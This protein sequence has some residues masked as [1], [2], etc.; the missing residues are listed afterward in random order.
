[1]EKEGQKLIKKQRKI[2]EKAIN[3]ANNDSPIFSIFGALFMVIV[4][5]AIGFFI[6]FAIRGCLN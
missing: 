5:L 4:N 1:M 6:G 3:H 2:N